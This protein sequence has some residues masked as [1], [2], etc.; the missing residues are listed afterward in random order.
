MKRIALVAA[1]L[2]VIVLAFAGVAMAGSN[3]TTVTQYKTSYND[4]YGFGPVS[5]SGVH[6]VKKD[7][8]TQESFTCTSTS[9]Q[10]LPNVSP[11]QVINWGPNQWISDFDHASLDKTFTGTV[12]A[13]GMSYSAVAT[14]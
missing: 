14:Y 2:G 4:V 6:Q 3:G 11:G 12:S 10:P 8:S 13:D 1:L 5:C 9:G 7:G